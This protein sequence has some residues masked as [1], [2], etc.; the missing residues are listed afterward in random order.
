[1]RI[2][3]LIITFGCL[4]TLLGFDTCL[5]SLRAN[6][7]AADA[8][9]GQDIGL[10]NI[11]LSKGKHIRWQWYFGDGRYS[12]EFAPKISYSIGAGY[13]KITLKV[14][15]SVSHCRDS[16]W[17]YLEIFPKP[18]SDFKSV[19]KYTDSCS[20]R[21]FT[22]YKTN[23]IDHS[24][25]WYLPNGDSIYIT[26]KNN[27]NI[28]DTIE[29]ETGTIALKVRS[30]LGCE[31][32]T[33][34]DYTLVGLEKLSCDNLKVYTSKGTLV[35][36]YPMPYQYQLYDEQGHLIQEGNSKDN[37]T[38]LEMLASGIYYLSIQTQNAERKII[39]T[40]VY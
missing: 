38:S 22:A 28:R 33:K 14:Y 19:I 3:L 31:S 9:P 10:A 27:L 12:E 18:E 13:R 8:C 2:L 1:M 17:K 35:I 23:P 7:V 34:K 20:Y 32:I 21:L 11:S 24:F 16:V 5:Y 29:V 26:G 40:I 25:M 39:K 37:R 4:Q 6:F 30:N 15:D 36:D